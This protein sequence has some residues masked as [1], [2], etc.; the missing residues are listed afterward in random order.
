MKR[1][2]IYRWQGAL[3]K[4]KLYKTIILFVYKF[5]AKT[6]TVQRVFSLLFNAKVPA[7][8]QKLFLRKKQLLAIYLN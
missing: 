4:T 3:A 7:K 1:P 5:W 6:H 8:K 2:A